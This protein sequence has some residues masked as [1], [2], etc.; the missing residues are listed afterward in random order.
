LDEVEGECVVLDVRA[1]FSI[2]EVINKRGKRLKRVGIIYTFETSKDRL[3]RLP[4]DD[5]E[6]KRS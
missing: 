5:S 1:L 4:R 2:F 3:L 6:L